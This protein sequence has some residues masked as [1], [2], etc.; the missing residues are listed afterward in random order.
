[1]V[2]ATIAHYRELREDTDLVGAR[3]GEFVNNFS[4]ELQEGTIIISESPE[5]GEFLTLKLN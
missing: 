3:R 4:H 5:F 1:M 2:I